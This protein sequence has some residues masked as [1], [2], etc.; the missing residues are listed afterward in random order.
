M[1]ML[2]LYSHPATAHQSKDT[3][4]TSIETFDTFKARENLNNSIYRR[5]VCGIQQHP[6]DDPLRENHQQIREKITGPHF[7]GGG[8]TEIYFVL[9]GIGVTIVGAEMTD[10]HPGSVVI[11]PPDTAHYTLPNGTVIVVV[12]T[13]PFDTDNYVALSSSRS[14]VMFDHK[15]Y[16]ELANKA[17]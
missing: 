11:T 5:L 8:E 9:E 6:P 12:N 16:M 2:K 7:H 14:D 3:M 17:V 10:L 13:P 15:Q 1:R 4:L